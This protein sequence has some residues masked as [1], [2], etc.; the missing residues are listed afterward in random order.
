MATALKPQLTHMAIFV[1]DMPKMRQFY[2][3]VFGLTVTDEGK[4][5]TA[6]VEMVFMSADPEE[7]HQFVLVSGRP[8]DVPFNVPPQLFRP[9]R[10]EGLAPGNPYDATLPHPKPPVQAVLRRALRRAA[11]AR[12]RGG[13]GEPPAPR[14]SSGHRRGARGGTRA[15]SGVA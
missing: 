8:E 11:L 14:V 13:L 10:P 7:H 12:S 1:G 6:P 4:H 3:D 15:F 5:P 2:M 9:G